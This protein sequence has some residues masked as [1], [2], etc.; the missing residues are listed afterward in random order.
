MGSLGEYVPENI[1]LTGGAGFIGSHVVVHLVKQYPH[2]R[3]VVLDKLDYCATVQ[4][5]SSVVD[6]GN[7]KFVRGDIRSKP[8]LDYLLREEKIDT[9][10]N[11]AASTHV[12]NSFQSS[13]SFTSNNILG[14]HILLEAARE[15]G[16]VERFIHVSTDE[17]YGGETSMTKEDSMLAPT[18]PYACTKAAAEFICR[19]YSTSFGLP[20][21]ISRG[22][23]A[24]GPNQFP[25]KLIAKSCC[26]LAAGQPVYVHGDGSHLRNY[27]YVTDYAEAF[28]VILHRGVTGTVYNIG[29]EC[30]KSTLDTVRDLLAIFHLDD[31]EDRY[32]EYVEDRT[33]NDKRYHIDSRKLRDLGW[34]QRVSW[35]E[36]LR[37][38][39]QWYRIP[40]NLQRWSNYA[41]GL[42]AHPSLERSE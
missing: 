26:L 35:E 28:D 15:Y 27:V 12:D 19:A 17:V 1:L 34:S 21:I 18:N 9:I 5:L 23:N 40:E 25:D 4:N 11:F 3:V 38:T 2:Y 16:K 20:I 33:F 24:Y 6:H 7:F 42:V 13:V 32:I 8:L 36:G 29:S 30:E 41:Q 22:N 14:C 31:Q 37:L 10:L 39:A